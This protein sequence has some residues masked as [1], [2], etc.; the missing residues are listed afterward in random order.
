MRLID[1]LENE[2]GKERLPGV[3]VGDT[4]EVYYLITEG[5]KERIQLFVGT[6]IAYS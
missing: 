6:I 4:V 3:H 2:L 5:D 1:R